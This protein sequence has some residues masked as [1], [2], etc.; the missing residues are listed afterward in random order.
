MNTSVVSI[1]SIVAAIT[2][3]FLIAVAGSSDADVLFGVPVF[4]ACAA[5]AF[6]VQWVA[7]IPAFIFQTEKHFDLI[8]SLTYIGLAVL[9]LIY[10][11]RD[12]GALLVAAMVIIWAAR[13]GSFLFVRV[14]SV[15]HDRRFTVLKRNVLQFLMTWTL[16]GLWVFLTFAAG[17]SALVSGKA[18]AVDGFVI[19]GACI[20]LVGFLIEVIADQQKSKFRKNARNSD[21]FISHGLWA[22]SRHPNY[23]GEIL[24]WL[25]IAVAASPVLEGWQHLTLVSPIFVFFLLTKISGVRILEAQAKRKWAGDL[26]YEE[27]CKKTPILMLKPTTGAQS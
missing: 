4:M 3:A 7:F 14:M 20:W 6:L 9:G 27:Y 25:G 26:D 21:K 19:I 22:W 10:S 13:L 24:L 5:I 16:Q 17:L 2:V 12:L 15:G 11:S 18:Y 1:I 23:F 8:G